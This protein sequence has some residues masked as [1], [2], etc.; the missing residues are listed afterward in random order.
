[1][2]ELFDKDTAA[3]SDNINSIA[4]QREAAK[5]QREE[6]KDTLF[7]DVE[8]GRDGYKEDLKKIILEDRNG[9][10]DKIETRKEKEKALND[11]V[12]QDKDKEMMPRP[13]LGALKTAIAGAEEQ[14][15]KP[16]YVKKGKKYLLFLQYIV[17][18]EGHL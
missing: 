16:K 14:M 1:M 3:E 6:A 13:D 2:K 5:V 17:E 12:Y 9:Y 11:L 7:K 18:F 4:E 8:E 10:R 15:V